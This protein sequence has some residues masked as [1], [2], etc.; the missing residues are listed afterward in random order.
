MRQRMYPGL[1][2]RAVEWNPQLATLHRDG[3]LGVADPAS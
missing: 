1:F 2:I 3:G